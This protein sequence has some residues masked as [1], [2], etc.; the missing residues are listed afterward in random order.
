MQH[1]IHNSTTT[2]VS[3]SR[4]ELIFSISTIYKDIHITIS[5]D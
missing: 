4:K 1:T 3:R 5:T 2:P